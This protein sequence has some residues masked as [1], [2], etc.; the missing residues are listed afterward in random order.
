MH[1]Y[2]ETN[3]MQIYFYLLLLTLNVPL[4]IGECA[5]GGAPVLKGV[6]ASSRVRCIQLSN[7]CC[8]SKTQLQSTVSARVLVRKKRKLCRGVKKAKE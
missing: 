6:F 3:N 5:P 2:L 1:K 4:R 7:L 8:N